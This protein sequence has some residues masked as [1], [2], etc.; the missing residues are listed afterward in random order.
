MLPMFIGV[1]T[2]GYWGS[3]PPNICVTNTSV[4]P[5]NI[6]PV[7]IGWLRASYSSNHT[8]E[9]IQAKMP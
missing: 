2:G 6:I 5:S 9:F 4:P 1:G 8:L 3:V 7:E